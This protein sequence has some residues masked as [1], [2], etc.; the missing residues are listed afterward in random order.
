[1]MKQ[2]IIIPLLIFGLAGCQQQ[3]L[4][5]GLDQDQVNEVI[6]VLQRSNIKANK[7]DQGKT[8]YSITVAPADFAAAVDTL[9]TH[10]LPSRPRMEIAKMFPSD[11]LVSSPRAEKARLY[12][13]IE[14]RL[15]QSLRSMEGVLSARVH[16]SYDLDTSESRVAKPVHLSAL[17]VYGKDIEATLMISD[18]KRFL[19]N[20]F[21]EVEYDNISVV[22]SRRAPAQYQSPG[23]DT[24][25]KGLSGTTLALS[26]LLL[27]TLVGTVAFLLWNKRKKRP[28]DA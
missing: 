10:D 7:A 4:L 23:L 6:A 1:M 16:V 3:D 26:L 11:S 5:K 22:L 13:A 28:V 19:K 25:Q 14:Q 17:A 8:G 15:E 20:S 18:I 9:K 27:L 2:L 24:Q 12:S 21:S